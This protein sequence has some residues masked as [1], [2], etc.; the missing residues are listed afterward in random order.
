MGTT[1]NPGYSSLIQLPDK[2]HG[3]AAEDDPSFWA[4]ASHV[5][6]QEELLESWVWTSPTPPL[7]P[8]ER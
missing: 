4:T 5:G 1:S 2:V 7:R 6:D 8:F 3:K